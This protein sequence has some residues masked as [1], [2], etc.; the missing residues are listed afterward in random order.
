MFVNVQICDVKIHQD[1]NKFEAKRPV[2]TIGTFDGVHL[3]HQKVIA[4]LKDFAKKYNGETVIFTFYPHPRQITSPNETNLRLL[5]TLEEKKQLLAASG[6]D[7]LI[8]YPFTK[9]FSELSYSEFVKSIL[10]E[11]IKTHCLVVGYDHKFG[12]DREG[13]YDY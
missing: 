2:V 7:H 8:I 10:I 3:G 12:K 13:G 1:I 6:I 5:T 9:Q 11:K 4:R